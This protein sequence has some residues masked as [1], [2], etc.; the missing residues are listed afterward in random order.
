MCKSHAT[1]QALIT[2]KC[3]V[4]CHLVR[5]DSSAIKFDRVEI[6]FIWALFYWLNHETDEGGEETRVPGE[7]P[8]RPR[9]S[10]YSQKR[11]QSRTFAQQTNT[12]HTQIQ[13]LKKKGKKENLPSNLNG[14][15]KTMRSLTVSLLCDTLPW[16]GEGVR[17]T[18]PPTVWITPQHTWYWL[19]CQLWV[20]GLLLLCCFW[21]KCCMFPLLSTQEVYYRCG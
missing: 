15:W 18:F 13:P 19:L 12:S 17:R 16:P 6:A 3:H 7:N 10:G 11:A 5:R 9:L 4:T 14:H 1:H 8:W 2:C 21:I 20:G